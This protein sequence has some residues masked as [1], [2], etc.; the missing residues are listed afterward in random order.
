ME[1]ALRLFDVFDVDS[2]PPLHVSRTAAVLAATLH[3]P[4]GTRHH[5][6][7]KA[8]RQ[9]DQVLAELA[10][11]NDLDAT[12]CVVTVWAVFVD[13]GLDDDG[14]RLVKEAAAKMGAS[15]QTIGGVE[16]NMH[17]VLSVRRAQTSEASSRG[18][19]KGRR[20]V[21]WVPPRTTPT[22]TSSSRTAAKNS[23]SNSYLDSTGYL[24]IALSS[25]STQIAHR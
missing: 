13:S 6:A 22:V 4:D 20:A 17:G 5:V 24:R 25:D 16:S 9:L 2:G 7:L 14:Q 19:L 15:V 3:A 10:G 21:N 18:L 11:H 8:M 1:A 23:Y 12:T